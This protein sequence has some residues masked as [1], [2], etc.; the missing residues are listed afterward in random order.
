MPYLLNELSN[1]IEYLLKVNLLYKIIIL[2]IHA[3]N[4]SLP[5]IIIHIMS[6]SSI[7][8]CPLNV[9]K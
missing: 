3:S 1:E 4:F 9:E 6:E 2:L 8:F 7:Q 5:H